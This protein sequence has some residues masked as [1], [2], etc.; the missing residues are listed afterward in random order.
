M[1]KNVRTLIEIDREVWSQIKAFAT[2]HDL[3][4][5]EVMNQLLSESLI[6]KGFKYTIPQSS[7]SKV[8]KRDAK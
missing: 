1:L 2:I 3:T 5:K 4:I 8:A 6:S 7:K